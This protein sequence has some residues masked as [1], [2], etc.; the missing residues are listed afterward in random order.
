[1]GS[2][3]FEYDR[4]WGNRSKEFVYECEACGTRMVGMVL[5]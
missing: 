3:V 4:E 1:M 2:S 5:V